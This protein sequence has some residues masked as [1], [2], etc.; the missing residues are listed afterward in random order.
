M[1]V[2]CQKAG[3]T[4][5]IQRC[6]RNFTNK[7]E[8]WNLKRQNVQ[9]VLK[10]R[11][12]VCFTGIERRHFVCNKDLALLQACSGAEVAMGA[13]VVAVAVGGSRVG[14]VLWRWQ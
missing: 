3:V 14:A 6:R 9:S 5:Y 12:S 2:Q 7:F 11:T 1:D 13:A 4:I 10:L 8:T